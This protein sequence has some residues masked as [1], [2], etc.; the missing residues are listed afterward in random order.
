MNE[1]FNEQNGLIIHFFLTSIMVGVIWVI[2]LVHYP[3]FR[4]I[5]REEYISFQ[6]FHMGSISFIVM[7]VMIFEILSGLLLILYVDNFELLLEISFLLLLI[8]WL[9]TALFFAQIHQKLS[10]GYN[11]NLVRRLVNLN[12][13]R[14]SLWTM[15]AFLI[16]YCLIGF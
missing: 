7:P 8:I 5:D 2:Q 3:S 9:V 10:K 15:R 12:W 13:I 11:V 4:F 16:A 14:T 6:N 1:I